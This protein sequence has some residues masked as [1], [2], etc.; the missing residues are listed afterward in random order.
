MNVPVP[1]HCTKTTQVGDSLFFFICYEDTSWRKVPIFFF[2]NLVSTLERE[3][4]YKWVSLFT[5]RAEIH[6]FFAGKN[7]YFLVFVIDHSWS[8]TQSTCNV[9]FGS[10]VGTLCFLDLKRCNLGSQFLGNNRTLFV[11]N[12]HTNCWGWI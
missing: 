7:K 10:V 3:K 2:S 5:W 6:W 8:S 11:P 9:L 12:K 1:A 4:N